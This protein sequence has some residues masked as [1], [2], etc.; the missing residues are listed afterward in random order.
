MRD[1]TRNPII[2]ALHATTRQTRQELTHT[3]AAGK[4]ITPTLN[5]MNALCEDKLIAKVGKRNTNSRGR[6]PVEYALTDAGTALAAT[7]LGDS[8]PAEAPAPAAPVAPT[9]APATPTPAPAAPVALVEFDDDVRA[10]ME[11]CWA[12]IEEAHEAEVAAAFERVER[13]KVA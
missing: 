8:A 11:A 1:S 2:L 3:T 5:V 10:Q 9:P 6:P 7:L 12:E 4:E 13:L